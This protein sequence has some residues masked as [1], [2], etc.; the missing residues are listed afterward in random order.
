M[1]RCKDKISRFLKIYNGLGGLMAWV[2]NILVSVLYLGNLIPWF[3][4]YW[5]FLDTGW[6][7]FDIIYF[8]YLWLVFITGYLNVRTF[9]WKNR[10]ID[11]CVTGGLSLCFNIYMVACLL[12]LCLLISCL[13]VAYFV[14]SVIGSEGTFFAVVQLVLGIESLVFLILLTIHFLVSTLVGPGKYFW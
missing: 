10:C 9:Y 14:A 6:K 2:G 3:I 12:I 7:A 8:F 13:Y 1:G 11:F 5:D 4:F